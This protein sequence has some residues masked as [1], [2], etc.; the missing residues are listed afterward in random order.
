MV[1]CVLAV[2]VESRYPTHQELVALVVLTLGVML[3][4][5][6]VRGRAAIRAHEQ[7]ASGGGTLGA[8]HPVLRWAGL[9]PAKP[10]GAA[11]GLVDCGRPIAPQRRISSLQPSL[12]SNSPTPHCWPSTDPTL[13]CCCRAPS[14]GGHT[15]SF[16]AYLPRSATEP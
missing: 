7:S 4:V 1:A 16:A 10:A 15:P 9:S 14:A 2:L 5:W 3:A 12:G 6:Q 8:C 11:A 13:T